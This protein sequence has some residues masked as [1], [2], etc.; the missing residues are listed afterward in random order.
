MRKTVLLL[1]LLIVT[2]ASAQIKV[3]INDKPITEATILKAEDIKKMEVAF[4]KP[5]KLS[6]YGTGRLYFWVEFIRDENDVI[7]DYFIIKEGSNAI[8]A[9]LADV[10][11]YYSLPSDTKGCGIAGPFPA[12]VLGAPRYFTPNGD[13]YN[14]TWNLRG[15]NADFNRNATIYIFDRYGKLIKQI[16]PIGSGWDGT[17][18]QRPLPAD[19]YWYS[20]KLDDGRIAKGHFALKR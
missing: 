7:E 4:D 15:A 20:I 19:D 11:T 6:Y 5:K 16:S 10:N 12:Y 8:E 18:N 17:Y 3:K 2:A 13:G 1:A 14:D 9:F